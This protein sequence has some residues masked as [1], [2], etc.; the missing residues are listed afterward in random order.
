M[1]PIL[2]AMTETQREVWFAAFQESCRKASE[3]RYKEKLAHAQKTLQDAED[4]K[5]VRATEKAQKQESDRARSLERSRL[6]EKASSLDET[7]RLRLVADNPDFP[8]DAFPKDWARISNAACQ[9]I[10]TDLVK[11]VLSRISEKR[12]GVWR[13][14]FQKLSRNA[15]HF[16]EP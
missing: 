11:A 13:E 4:R 7:A 9:H 12:K 6:L 16:D 10:T 1:I 15:G 5:L 3:Q 8:L 14:L 2:D